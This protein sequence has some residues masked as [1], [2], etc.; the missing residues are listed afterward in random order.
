MPIMMLPPNTTVAND[1]RLRCRLADGAPTGQW[2]PNKS[3]QRKPALMLERDDQFGRTS[4]TFSLLS[5][6][7]G[8]RSALAAIGAIYGR[9][10]A[11][12]VIAIAAA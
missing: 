4:G 1:S 6:P 9:C 3:L 8:G 7:A 2:A 10:P 5:T 12:A 11:G